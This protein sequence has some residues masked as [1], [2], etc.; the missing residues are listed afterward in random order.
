M[1]LEDEL[2]MRYEQHIRQFLYGGSRITS[3]KLIS[4][5]NEHD[6]FK[7]LENKKYFQQQFFF[8]FPQ[9]IFIL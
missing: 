6:I 1:T 2:L 5:S 4:F 9:H 7:N 8:F 3:F